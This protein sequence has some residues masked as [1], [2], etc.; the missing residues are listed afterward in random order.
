LLIR[1]ILKYAPI[2]ANLICSMAA[3]CLMPM[4]PAGVLFIPV[5]VPLWVLTSIYFGLDAYYLNNASSRIG[6][7]AHLGGAIYGAM[8]YFGYLRNYGGVWIMLRRLL[9]R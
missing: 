7:S 8:Y 2:L 5:A 1:M 4:A 6:H 9:R 3:T